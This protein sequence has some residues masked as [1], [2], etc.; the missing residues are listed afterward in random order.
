MDGNRHTGLKAQPPALS[1][2]SPAAVKAPVM[3]KMGRVDKVVW[4]MAAV[5][6]GLYLVAPERLFESLKFVAAALIQISSYLLFSIAVAAYAQATGSEK[7]IQRAF[8]ASR[9]PPLP[10][11]PCSEACRHS[12]R[13]ASSPSSPACSAPVSPWRR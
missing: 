3:E 5:Y 9:R 8:P 4:A 13:A 10:P 12:V 6:L 1:L 11:P 7:L 2:P